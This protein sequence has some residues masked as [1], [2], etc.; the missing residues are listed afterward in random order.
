MVLKILNNI[1]VDEEIVWKVLEIVKIGF[2]YIDDGGWMYFYYC[3]SIFFG[4]E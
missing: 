4:D 2:N 1:F 3:V